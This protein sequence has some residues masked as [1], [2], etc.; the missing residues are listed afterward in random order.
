MDVHIK[1]ARKIGVGAI[2]GVVLIQA[3]SSMFCYDHNL[4]EFFS[5]LPLDIGLPLLPALLCLI[6]PNPLL[7]VGG[8]I[9]FVPWLV[10]AFMVDCVL[11]YQGGGASMIYVAVLFWGFPSTL[12]GLVLAKLTMMLFKVSIIK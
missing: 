11:P 8:A 5:I 4:T 2:L 6:S 12:V 3:L 7:A 9:C 10:L 1:K